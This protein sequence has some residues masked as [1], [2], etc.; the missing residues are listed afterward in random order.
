[1]LR[2]AETCAAF[3]IIWQKNIFISFSPSESEGHLATTL[4]F[5]VIFF[6]SLFKMFQSWNITDE[7]AIALKALMPVQN[8]CQLD[9]VKSANLLL[10][11][12]SLDNILCLGKE[13]NNG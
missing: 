8:K 11:L 3:Y 4:T 13:M 7:G 6:I 9:Q 10:M 1:M 12:Q 5:W 2:E